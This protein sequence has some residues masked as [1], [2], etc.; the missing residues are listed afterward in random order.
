MIN[1]L[2]SLFH[3]PERGWDPIAEAYAT[4]YANAEWQYVDHKFLDDLEEKIGGFSG[5]TIL[6]LGGGAGQYSIAFAKRRA[7]VTWHDVSRIY[8]DITRKFATKEGVSVKLS[9]GYLEDA[10]TFIETPFDFVFN[11]ICWNYCMDD[12]K[13]AHLVY[14]LVKPGG[15]GYI[16]CML[17]DFKE[18][19]G[20]HKLFHMLY[21]RFGY[22][23]GHPMPPH[24]K[25]GQLLHSYPMQKMILDYT[26]VTNDRIFFIKNAN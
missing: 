7:L 5:K 15:M 22:K 2:H 17:P 24:G 20:R 8:M 3:R 12:S 6:D 4:S 26:S 16:D 9:I 23:I 13:F 14:S 21:Y 11:R 1:R 25:V 10:S 18:L 19:H